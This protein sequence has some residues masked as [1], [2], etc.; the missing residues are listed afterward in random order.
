MKACPKSYQCFPDDVGFSPYCGEPL[1][2]VALWE[3]AGLAGTSLDDLTLERCLSRDALGE[4]YRASRGRMQFAV[5]VFAPNV[6][7]DEARVASLTAD[8]Q[9]L[10]TATHPAIVR[11]LEI[12]RDAAHGRLYVVSE[13]FEGRTLR[14]ILDEKR[15]LEPAE[16]V[17]M[18]RLLL[19]G[20]TALHAMGVQHGMLRPEALVIERGSNG[21]RTL[22]LLDAALYRLL[23]LDAAEEIAV[24]HPALF[25]DL[26]NYLAPEVIAGKP[27]CAASDVYG[28]GIVAFELLAGRPPFHGGQPA[29]VFKRHRLEDPIPVTL[30]RGNVVLPDGLQDL[31]S[32]A[33]GKGPDQRFETATALRRALDVVVPPSAAEREGFL[34]E[35]V[36]PRAA[37]ALRIEPAP[38]PAP[39]DAVARIDEAVR[40]GDTLHGMPGDLV[41]QV[42]H[43]LKRERRQAPTVVDEPTAPGDMS[44]PD[45][46]PPAEDA[47]RRRRRRRRGQSQPSLESALSAQEQAPSEAAAPA[48]PAPPPAADHDVPA[49]TL[50]AASDAPSSP[51]ATQPEPQTSDDEPQAEPVATDALAEDE[52]PAAPDAPTARES[53]AAERDAS[54]SAGTPRRTRERLDSDAWFSAVSLDDLP[55]SA[56]D[57][58]ALEQARRSQ[59]RTLIAVLLVIVVLVGAFLVWLML[60]ASDTKRAE[61]AARAS[62][63][64]STAERA[65]LVRQ[66]YDQALADGLLTG[67]GSAA[68]QLRILS[69]LLPEAELTPLLEAWSR[70]THVDLEERENH[71]R[72]FDLDAAR[73]LTR[74]GD[75]ARASLVAL[76]PH[77]RVMLLSAVAA[78][79]LGVTPSPA[80]LERIIA[81]WQAIA[82]GWSDLADFAPATEQPV[83]RERA[84]RAHDQASLW[85]APPAAP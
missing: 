47:G 7:L 17:P 60:P 69:G 51:A 73:K 81:T 80:D 54:P 11:V 1:V 82:R 66:T 78:S 6:T 34:P 22:R 30:A 65:A 16:V 53:P 74:L 13:W 14:E 33:L 71:A 62:A 83:L 63:D 3:P 42:A 2:P 64:A 46:R 26:A 44:M 72:R 43:Q 41:S 70:R 76:P 36:L 50:D 40:A 24:D 58:E 52:A 8:L 57:H 75:K 31:L 79:N 55:P 15:H 77:G 37:P 68:S 59:R 20:L 48:E 67:P 35:D 27:P 49:A 18:L 10:Q 21:Q 23:P 45:T 39:Q 32:L 28:C 29:T 38:R 4:L 9:Q 25:A 12:K 5:R 84:L 19:D 85:Q 56:L 61:N